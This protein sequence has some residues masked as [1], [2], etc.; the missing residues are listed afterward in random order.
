M[1]TDGIIVYILNVEITNSTNQNNYYF[2]KS[3]TKQYNGIMAKESKGR[4][5]KGQF[6][7]GNSGRP[8]KWDSPEKLERDIE[9]Y[10]KKCDENTKKELYMGKIKEIPH[11]EPYTLEGL[12]V[13]LKCDVQTL[14]NYQKQKGYEPFFGIIKQARD[15]VAHSMVKMAM[16]YDCHAGFTQFLLKNHFGFADKQEIETTGETII[17]NRPQKP[18]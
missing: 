18:E 11:P 15:K 14:K 7:I 6:T 8:K 5:A 4:N 2:C 17:V 10:F 1:D 12:A 9:S 16:M 13:H 3:A